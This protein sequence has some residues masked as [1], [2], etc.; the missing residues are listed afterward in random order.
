M[1]GQHTTQKVAMR[2][3]RPLRCQ[4]AEAVVTVA[5]RVAVAGADGRLGAGR[6]DLDLIRASLHD[7]GFKPDLLSGLLVVSDMKGRLG[8]SE[9][10][11][12]RLEV[13]NAGSKTPCL[14]RRTSAVGRRIWQTE[15]RG[16]KFES[17]DRA[18]GDDLAA[19]RFE[20]DYGDRSLVCRSW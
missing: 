6:E 12:G 9:G 8:R 1:L 17:V 2:S 3:A 18:N 13:W 11:D 15:L 14:D 4:R 10:G 20:A 19:V 5:G 16:S 7:R